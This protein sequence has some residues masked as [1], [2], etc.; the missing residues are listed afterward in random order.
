[1]HDRCSIR[2]SRHSINTDEREE[3]R[4]EKSLGGASADEQGQF[5]TRWTSKPR[6]GGFGI[7]CKHAKSR[8]I[9]GPWEAHAT[10]FS[11]PYLRVGSRNHGAAGLGRKNGVGQR[12]KRG[13]H[14]KKGEKPG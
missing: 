3:K 11:G 5:R 10:G 1:G 14:K 2:G 12:G 8:R 4:L 7:G 13:A 6:S 9:G